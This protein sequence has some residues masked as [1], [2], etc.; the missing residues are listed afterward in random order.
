MSKG[1]SNKKIVNDEAEK[2]ED[3]FYDIRYYNIL[4]H[5]AVL[6]LWLVV[7]AALLIFCFSLIIGGIEHAYHGW[8]DVW[9]DDEQ[10]GSVQSGWGFNLGVLPDFL[11]GMVGILA[12]FILEWLVFE[13]IKN[14]SKYR[15]II[16]CLKIEFEKILD[17]LKDKRVPL[18]E[19]I[20]DDIVLS[21]ENSVIIFN[22]PHY[23]F[24]IRS[25]QGEKF[26][27]LLQEIHGRISRRNYFLK[28]QSPS[29]CKLDDCSTEYYEAKKQ[30]CVKLICEKN[31]IIEENGNLYITINDRRELLNEIEIKNFNKKV[32]KK[33]VDNYCI[34]KYAGIPKKFGEPFIINE[35]GEREEETWAHSIK[36]RIN[37]LMKVTMSE[38]K[39]TKEGDI[40][41]DTK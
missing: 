8:T 10:T 18:C 1:N 6:W 17:T 38:Y 33:L 23:F 15:T 31:G 24:L 34:I 3:H 12:G 5:E 9:T 25:K 2:Q 19:I 26:L 36:I 40:N 7:F 37:N 32:Q 27:S 4:A 13:K 30:E 39:Y 21:A 28:E 16:S 20:L 41:A 22:L 35:K 29:E 11:G 14:L